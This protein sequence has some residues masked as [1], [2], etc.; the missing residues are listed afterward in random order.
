MSGKYGMAKVVLNYLTVFT[1][2][3]LWHDISL[4]L[5]IW[6][7]LVVFFMLPEILAG[8]LFPRKRWLNHLTA[9]RCLCGI[10]VV[11]NLMMMMMANLVGFAVG[12]DGLKSIIS[13]IFKDY[14]GDSFI[15]TLDFNGAN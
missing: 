5:L 10:G 6:G 13:G 15:L 11:G 8:M 1:F 2:V 7:W 12:V 9:Y 14:S 4:N 3:A